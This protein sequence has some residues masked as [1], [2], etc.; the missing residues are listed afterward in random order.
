MEIV[1][2]ELAFDHEIDT[3]RWLS[4]E[5]ATALLSYPRDVDVLQAATLTSG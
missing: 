4:P 1:G 2:G 5:E 3:A